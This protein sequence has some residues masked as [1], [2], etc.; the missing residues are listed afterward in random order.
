MIL[1]DT[2]PY[3]DSTLTVRHKDCLTLLIDHKR[4]AVFVITTVVLRAMYS[5]SEH[6]TIERE[7]EKK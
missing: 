6:N 7:V 3:I 5:K 1:L 4:N 2:V